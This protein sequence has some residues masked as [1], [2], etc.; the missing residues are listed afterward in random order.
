M[1][2][3]YTR[4]EIVGIAARQPEAKRSPYRAIVD[5]LERLGVPRSESRIAMIEPPAEN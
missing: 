5:N 2:W 1:A 4:V 3:R